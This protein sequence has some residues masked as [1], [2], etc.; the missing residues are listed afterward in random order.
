MRC[1]TRRSL[2]RAAAATLALGA[3]ATT[4]APAASAGPRAR[5][6]EGGGRA[7]MPVVVARDFRYPGVPDDLRPGTYDFTFVNASRKQPHEIVFFKVEDDAKA[8][9]VVAAA[10]NE[11]FGF[12]SDFRGVSFAE[13]LDIQRTEEFQ[14]GEETFVVGRAD[15]SDE[16]RYA[17]ICFV[18]DERTGKPHYQLGMVGVLDVE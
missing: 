3:L 6:E 11:D 16:G 13:P 4:A 5:A 10:D 17:Y 15:L 8:G 12:F 2:R 18:P 14:E 1:S 9:D 7:A